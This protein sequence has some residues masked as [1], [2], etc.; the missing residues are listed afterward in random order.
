ML[1]WLS[2]M[3]CLGLS[4]W[5]IIKFYTT[6]SLTS[7]QLLIAYAIKIGF[8]IIYIWVFTYYFSD[9]ALF[10]DSARFFSDGNLINSVFY[11]SPT[12]FF[13]LLLGLN[14]N[15]PHSLEIM[16]NTSIWSTGPTTDW[17]NDN[18]L[19]LKL[20][21]VIRFFSF[22]N[23]YVHAVVFAF[24]SF[25]GI[26]LIFKSFKSLIHYKI[27]FWFVIIGFPN[28]AFWS[29]ALL[30]ESIF[31]F[32]LGLWC[33]SVKKLMQHSFN[34]S[35]IAIIAGIILVINKPYAGFIIIGF[36]V[37]FVMGKFFDWSKRALIFISISTLF[38]TILA[39]TIPN[40]FNLTNKIS[41]KQNDLN[42]LAKGGI[43]FVTDSAFCVFP[44]SKLSSFKRFQKDSIQVLTEVNGGTYKLFGQT[45]FKPFS[46]QPSPIKYAVYLVYPP[47]TSYVEPVLINY[48]VVQ[49][50]KNSGTALANVFIRPFPSDNGDSL[51]FAN[52]ISNLLLIGFIILAFIKRKSFKKMDYFLITALI[53]AIILIALLIGWSVPIFGAIVRYKIPIEILLLIL[54]FTLI[55]SKENASP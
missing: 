43:A 11:E 31:I 13:R 2:F 33:W 10:G 55:K 8:G 34:F 42:N 49:L 19:I 1:G 50:I 45:E 53:G 20:N 24:I 28:L 3:L 54:G 38:L 32:G 51:K 22:G 52:F 37:F 9:G 47:S 15:Q 29:S 35:I 46:I 25:S 12:D 14:P 6:H 5:L 27:Y 7:A 30:K 41:H 18:R 21:S 44:Y 16:Q 17:F 36:T 48:S 23:I 4:C 26:F 40:R 39:F